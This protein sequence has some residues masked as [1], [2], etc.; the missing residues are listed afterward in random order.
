MLNCLGHA[1][2]NLGPCLTVARITLA[3]SSTL[4]PVSALANEP[5]LASLGKCHLG[6]NTIDDDG[7]GGGRL[8]NAA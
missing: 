5:G 3:V 6:C 8:L 1:S 7:V 2:F 4:A